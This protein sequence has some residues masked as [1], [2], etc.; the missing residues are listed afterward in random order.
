[1]PDHPDNREIVINFGETLDRAQQAEVEP[2][3]SERD[4]FVWYVGIAGYVLFNASETWKVLLGRDLA[5]SDLLALSV[6]WTGAALLALLAHLATVEWLDRDNLYYHALRAEVDR[7]RSVGKERPL[8]DQEIVDLIDGARPHL[9]KL[10]AT[11]RRHD[12]WAKCLRRAAFAS[13]CLAF[14]WGLI[15]PHFVR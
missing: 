5:A 4:R 11:L 12:W 3:K 7:L 8:R 13:L 15:G 9:A 10:K 2:R 1:M 6:P 14:A